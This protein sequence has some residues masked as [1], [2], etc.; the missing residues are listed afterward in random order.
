MDSGEKAALA[1]TFSEWKSERKG[2]IPM[3]S[4]I[5]YILLLHILLSVLQVFLNF[6]WFCHFYSTRFK[7]FFF[8][9]IFWN[10][11]YI[12]IWTLAACSFPISDWL[13]TL[14]LLYFQRNHT[15]LIRKVRVFIWHRLLIFFPSKESLEHLTSRV[16]VGELIIK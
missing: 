8:F 4:F 6:I 1:A 9:Y 16:S 15:W 12:L 10:L 7:L 3:D 2:D 13:K 11:I 5:S 14:V